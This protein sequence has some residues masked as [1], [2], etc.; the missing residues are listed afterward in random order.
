MTGNMAPLGKGK[1]PATPA[2]EEEDLE[3]DRALA[4]RMASG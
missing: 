1:A 4:A 3:A 2:A